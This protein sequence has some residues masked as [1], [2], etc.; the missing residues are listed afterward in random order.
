MSD[1]SAGQSGFHTCALPSLARKRSY[2]STD[3]IWKD[4]PKGP[5]WHYSECRAVPCGHKGRGFEELYDTGSDPYPGVTKLVRGYWESAKAVISP[6]GSLRVNIN[7]RLVA[8]S[9]SLRTVLS[10]AIRLRSFGDDEY[11][12]SFTGMSSKGLPL[13]DT[14]L[15]AN[16]EEVPRQGSGLEV[17]ELPIS[18]YSSPPE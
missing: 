9:A 17:Y 11:Y 1:I 13:R 14:E 3:R 7:P 15:N 6:I 16:G 18:T 4:K 8:I 12:A 5:G 10:K 2:A